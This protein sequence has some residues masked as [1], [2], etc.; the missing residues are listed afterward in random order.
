MRRSRIDDGGYAGQLHG[1]VEAWKARREQLTATPVGDSLAV[2]D[3]RAVAPAPRITLSGLR[4][5][6]LECCDRAQTVDRLAKTLGTGNGQA[7]PDKEEIQA[8]LEEFVRGKLMIKEG[9][10]YLSLPLMA[11]LG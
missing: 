11:H 6:L 5:T 7:G 1:E 10:G 4:R 2:N 9:G 8:I 3:S